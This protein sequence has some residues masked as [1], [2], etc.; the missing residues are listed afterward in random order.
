[1]SN[2]LKQ[3]EE[4]HIQ[5]VEPKL[6]LKVP[7]TAGHGLKFAGAL[8]CIVML[9]VW[10]FIESKGEKKKEEKNLPAADMVQ[11]LTL[12]LQS[13]EAQSA[14]PSLQKSV[15]G[16]VAEY[17][18][19]RVNFS[20]ALPKEWRAEVLGNQLFLRRN[21]DERICQIT[22]HSNS[23]TKGHIQE[24]KGKEAD[25]EAQF[26]RETM[27]ATMPEGVKMVTVGQLLSSKY[28]V[29]TFSYA[30]RISGQITAGSKSLEQTSV[31]AVSASNK[32]LA[33]LQ[34]MN[35]GGKGDA[36][37]EMASIAKSLIVSK[38]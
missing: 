23:D 8:V 37:S 16:G 32:R 28:A 25:F 6:E 7:P 31:N 13:P 19:N 34:C 24:I 22:A 36:N 14:Q 12:E 35:M 9:V 27:G 21:G 15:K 1:M 11:R 38:A 2:E 10:F 17:S 33:R 20:I 5:L 29:D 4:T 30:V 18:V 26:V 3:T